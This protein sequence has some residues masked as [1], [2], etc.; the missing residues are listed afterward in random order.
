[1]DREK[2]AKKSEEARRCEDPGQSDPR[3][4]Q[5]D[6]AFRAAKRRAGTACTIAAD[7]VAPAWEKYKMKMVENGLL[8]P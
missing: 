8:Y 2:G 7:A 1:M 6:V 4:K 5:E 3:R